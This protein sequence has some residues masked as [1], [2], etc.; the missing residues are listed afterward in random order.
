MDKIKT[1]SVWQNTKTFFPIFFDYLIKEYGK[2][3]KICIVGASDGRFVLPLAKYGY[4]ILAIENDTVLI[5]GGTVSGPNDTTIKVLG[6]K[7]RL[8]I[9]K[10]TSKVEILTKNFLDIKTSLKADAIFTSSTWDCTINHSRPLKEY[11]MRMQ[12]IVKIGGIFCAEYMMPCEARHKKIEHFLE[13]KQINNFF[14]SRKWQILEEFFTPV[15]KDEPHI[16][17]ITSHNHRMGFFM[18]KK[19]K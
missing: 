5:D 1:K 6:L 14:D 18:A 16:G 4:K 3:T 7:K 10:I 2:K 8:A 11:I 17:K 19:L 15:F 9:E 12:E 13:E